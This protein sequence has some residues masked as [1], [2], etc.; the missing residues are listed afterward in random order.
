MEFKVRPHQASS[1][2]PSCHALIQAYYVGMGVG[3]FALNG[4][5]LNQLESFQHL[6]VVPRTVGQTRCSKNAPAR[7]EMLTAPSPYRTKF[8]SFLHRIRCPISAD[9]TIVASAGLGQIQHFHIFGLLPAEF[10]RGAY[11]EKFS[12]LITYMILINSLP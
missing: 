8:H 1:S 9:S 12:N 10:K 4:L 6:C 7:V 11:S 2:R 3:Q 5:D